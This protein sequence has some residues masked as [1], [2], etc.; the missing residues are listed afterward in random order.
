VL[1]AAEVRRA[2]PGGDKDLAWLTAPSRDRALA[3]TKAYT[4][5]VREQSFVRGRDA[6]LAPPENV[7]R[8]V[9]NGDTSLAGTDLLALDGRLRL[10]WSGWRA[11]P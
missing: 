3:L 8:T 10:D 6:V 7:L 11:A 4:A 5:I 1:A 2:A 9:E